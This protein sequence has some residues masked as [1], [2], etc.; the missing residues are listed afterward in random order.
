VLVLSTAAVS[1]VTFTGLWPSS[2]PV[3]AIFFLV[4]CPGLAWARLLRV[5]PA[6]NELL[7]GIAL[8]L[9]LDTIVT[10]A[11][12]YAHVSSK[13]VNLA[14]LVAITLGGLLADPALRRRAIGRLRPAPPGLATRGTVT[15]GTVT[16][17]TV[18]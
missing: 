16:R 4:L 13:R 5:E 3:L 6:L 9:A 15:R 10:T 11:L 2:R 1:F 14:L 8:S 18:A 12:L 7:L 17:E